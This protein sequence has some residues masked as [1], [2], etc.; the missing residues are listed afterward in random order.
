MLLSIY[1]CG[2]KPTMGERMMSDSRDVE[3]FAE[4]WNEGSELV[5]EGEKLQEKGEQQVAEGNEN[6]RAG[7]RLIQRGQGMM[8]QS[9]RIYQGRF[10]T[11][12]P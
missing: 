8:E 10:P 9:E 12:S 6:I 2:S 4:M 7:K 1:G 11:P 5:M 3:A